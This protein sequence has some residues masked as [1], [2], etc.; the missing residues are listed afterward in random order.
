MSEVIDSPEE[1]GRQSKMLLE[2]LAINSKEFL[3]TY[4][5]LGEMPPESDEYA[6]IEGKLYAQVNQVRFDAEDVIEA[7]DA[8]VDEMPD[9][10]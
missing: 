3:A 2:Q 7:M 4:E 10:E 8:Q 1:L 6:Q 5:K 9:D